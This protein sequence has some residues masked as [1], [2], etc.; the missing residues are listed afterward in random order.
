MSCYMT[1]NKEKYLSYALAVLFPFAGLVYSLYNWQKPWSK[2]VFW[3]VCIYLG[4]IMILITGNGLED[5]GRDTAR[6]VMWFQQISQSQTSLWDIIGNYGQS[7]RSLDLYQPISA[8][9]VS[10]FTNNSH[11][12][13]AVY[14]FVF[15]FFYS[16]NVWYILDKHSNSYSRIAIIAITLLFLV[17]PIW[18]I[19]AVRMWTAAQVFT[20]GLLPYLLEKDKSRL[21]WVILTP[22][23]HFSFLYIT[24]LSLLFIILLNR[25]KNLDRYIRIAAIIFIATLFLDSLSLSSVESFLTNI[26]PSG[27]ANRIVSYTD[28]DYAAVVQ[29]SEDQRNWYVNASNTILSWGLAIIMI[30]LIPK[31]N[32]SEY[33]IDSLLLYS[34]L[35][36]SFANAVSSIPSGYRFSIIA[37]MFSVPIFLLYLFKKQ[38]HIPKYIFVIA[39]TLC[40]PLIVELRKAFD[41]YSISL[42][43]GNFVTYGLFE[44]NES[45]MDMIKSFLGV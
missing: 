14:A 8:W 27:F 38:T 36:G 15:G 34:F 35:I 22:L 13:F 21:I 6:Y 25:A 31:K 4:L 24:A 32:R 5:T 40:I 20:F 17:C 1:S 42:F 43:F 18:K 9:L 44:T 7:E 23:F 41:Y 16:R 3:I 45:L 29:L 2:N 30:S 28:E 33:D 19:S 10:R 12:L 39:L 11:I 37:N 26:S